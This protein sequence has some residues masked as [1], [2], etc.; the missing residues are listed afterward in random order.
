[1]SSTG[2]KQHIRASLENVIPDCQQIHPG[3]ERVAFSRSLILRHPECD[4]TLNADTLFGMA[5][6]V[7]T[8]GFLLAV[9]SALLITCNRD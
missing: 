5:A 6:L 1:M 2:R 8:L 3:E 7:M 9:S 4:A